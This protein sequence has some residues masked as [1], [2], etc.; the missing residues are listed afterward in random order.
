MRLTVDAHHVVYVAPDVATGLGSRLDVC[1][2]E[3]MIP[4][5]TGVVSFIYCN[6]VTTRF[7]ILLTRMGLVFANRTVTWM[8]LHMIDPFALE[9]ATNL[10]WRFKKVALDEFS[11]GVHEPS[12]LRTG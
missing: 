1:K 2:E 12:C 9:C 8:D 4:K 3:D 5:P 11:L 10:L 6:T 7:E